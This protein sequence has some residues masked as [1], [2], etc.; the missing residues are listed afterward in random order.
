MK[1]I[2]LGTGT[3]QGVP[4]IGCHCPV[5]MSADQRDKR[6]RTSVYIEN[7]DERIVIDCGPDFRQQM[8]GEKIEK[9]DAVLLTHAH[10]DHVAGL[11][12]VR[13]YNF[14]LHREMD[15][16]AT[17][18]VQAILRKEFDYAFEDNP[19]PGAPRIRLHDFSS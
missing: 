19:Y 9:L 8:L 6:L 3:S 2:F 13:A 4:V 5:C 16:Y 17:G 11:D 14:I 7:G 12:D 18:D 15:I 1:V 10:K